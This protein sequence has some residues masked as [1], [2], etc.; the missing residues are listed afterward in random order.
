MKKDRAGS[1][2]K[3]EIEKEVL[4][5]Y[6]SQRDISIFFADDNNLVDIF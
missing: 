5:I 2:S 3:S 1:E 4:Y 6:I